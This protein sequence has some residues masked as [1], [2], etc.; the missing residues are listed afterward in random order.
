MINTMDTITEKPSF[1]IF[2]S[3]LSLEECQD[4]MAWGI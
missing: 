2:P 3:S 1:I 4:I